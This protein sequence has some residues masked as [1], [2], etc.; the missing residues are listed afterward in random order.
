MTASAVRTRS[1]IRREL[2]LGMWSQGAI[3]A[4]IG[5]LLDIPRGSVLRIVCKARA[6]GDPRAAYRCLARSDNWRG[7][8]RT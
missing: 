2:V 5:H 1:R 6:E 3:A 4:T 8:D 7:G